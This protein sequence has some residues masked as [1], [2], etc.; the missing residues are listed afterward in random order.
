MLPDN[1][2]LEIFNI[3]LDQSGHIGA[4]HTLVHVCR[5]WR[6]VVFASPVRLNLRLLCKPNRS[7]AITLDIWPIVPIVVDFVATGT[8]PQGMRNIIAALEQHNRMSKINIR[9]IPN[10]L[11]KT[12]AAIRGPFPTLTELAISS[13]DEAV[14]VVPDS[15]L[16]G[17]TPQLRTFQLVGIPFPALG[18]LLLSTSNLV[19]LD[20]RNIPHSGY[21]SSQE[22][23][24]GLST[25][26]GLKKIALEFQSPR[27]WDDQVSWDPPPLTR[28]VFPALT[29]L[30]FK[31]DSQYLEAIV[32]RIDAPLLDSL[33]IT[34][35]N[36]LMFDTQLLGHFVSRAEAFTAVHRADVDFHAFG[37]QITLVRGNE[38][39]NNKTLTLL[40][41]CKQSDWQLPSIAQVCNSIIPPLP[42]LGML[43]IGKG[44]FQRLKWYDDM[45]NTEWL[46]LLRPF[47]CVKDL[48]LSKTLVPLVALALQELDGEGVTQMLPLL[49]DIFLEGPQPSG[50]VKE[51]VEKFI[52]ARLLSGY[53]VT[54][55]VNSV[56]G[57]AQLHPMGMGPTSPD[58]RPRA[59]RKMANA[60][61]QPHIDGPAWPGTM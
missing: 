20:L 58:I 15:F 33:K 56:S 9:D 40:I 11:L 30:A 23:V 13:D 28:I 2:L 25:S 17:S 5:Q 14:P 54:M 47:T 29:S 7:V 53:P 51:A 1:V 18:K 8:R 37:V 34:F 36:Q 45:E 42:T 50:A 52:A 22:I 60:V 27:S 38:K 10:S 26:R 12:L 61:P 31:G 59:P 3:Y 4:W 24:A 48:V 57:G 32:S 55:K 19:D 43:R 41:L 35:F 44:Q 39:S 49:Q 21:I 6:C 46:E 16:G